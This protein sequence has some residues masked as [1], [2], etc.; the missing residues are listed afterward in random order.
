MFCTRMS[1]K[2]HKIDVPTIV[3][4]PG[5]LSFNVMISFYPEK[6]KVLTLTFLKH[7]EGW[8]LKYL[9]KLNLTVILFQ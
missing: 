5:R 7:H 1:R 8:I 4:I 6:G 9:L 2:L 3:P